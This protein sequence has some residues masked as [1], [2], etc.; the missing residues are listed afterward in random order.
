MFH[1]YYVKMRVLRKVVLGIILAIFLMQKPHWCHSKG[2]DINDNCSVDSEGNEYNV[3]ITTFIDPKVSFI[4]SFG[5]MY[6]L[7]VL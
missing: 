7:I 5:C 1:Y 6:F 3:M 2:D 4:I